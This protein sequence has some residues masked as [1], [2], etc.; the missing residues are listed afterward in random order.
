MSVSSNANFGTGMPLS[1]GAVERTSWARAC[2][3]S[4]QRRAWVQNSEN[5]SAPSEL[6]VLW[7]PRLDVACLTRELLATGSACEAS[8]KSSSSN[9]LPMQGVRQRCQTTPSTSTVSPGWM[10]P[11]RSRKS[12]TVTDCGTT[13]AV[14]AC[15]WS[16]TRTSWKSAMQSSPGGSGWNAFEWHFMV[17]GR[18]T[19]GSQAVRFSPL[20]HSVGRSNS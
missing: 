13:P 17:L 20:A 15:I 4:R 10:L 16:C 18:L 1:H 14:K 5:W 12:E 6:D 8:M 19:F 7:G 11:T 2:H 3:S 9:L